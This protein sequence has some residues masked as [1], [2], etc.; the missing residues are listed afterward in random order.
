MVVRYGRWYL[1]CHAHHVDAV[2]TYRVD[3][4]RT[5]EMLAEA[6]EPPLDL[7]PVAALEQHLGVG[8]EHHTRVAFAAPVEEVA[9]WVRP[10]MGRLEPTD[11][12]CVLVG[13]TSNPTMY[14]A[15]WLT[16]VPLPFRVEGG[17]ELRAAVGA[18]ADRFSAA[19][20]PDTDGAG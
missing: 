20:R 8:W 12:G 13:S 10:P 7:D 15:E 2:R 14:A 16:R 1:L 9:R 4:I 3:R 17:P 11:E 19:L 6:F 5:V 18:L